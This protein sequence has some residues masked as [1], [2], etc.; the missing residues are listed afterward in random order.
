[1]KDARP[2]VVLDKSFFQAVCSIPKVE[3][4]LIWKQISDRYQIIIPFILVEEVWTNLAKLGNKNPFVVM[5]MVLT[6]REM[7]SCWID[8]EIEIIFHELVQKKRIKTFP[9]PSQEV[10]TRLWNTKPSDPAFSRWLDEKRQ[11]KEKALRERIQWHNSILP[12]GKFL[13]IKDEADLFTHYV[14][15]LFMDILDSNERTKGLLE[16][17]FGGL[18]RQR[19]PNLSRRI[20]TAFSNYSKANFNQFPVTLSYIMAGMFYFY[21]P[22]CR[23]QPSPGEVPRKI[24]GR[25]LSE[26]RNNLADQS[27][28]ACALI[29]DRIL[30]Q[31]EGMGNIMKAFKKC[32]VWEGEILFANPRQSLNAQMSS[33]LI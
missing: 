12:S 16:K 23:V 8:D 32:G 1:M 33:I 29:C 7:L 25:K 9:P 22:L 18:F 11:L 4:E 15:K 27:Y 6:L 30:T 13:T 5:E 31:D 17:L 2:T 24:I 20:E 10:I 14:R 28:V 21:A 3:R 26:Q 19:H